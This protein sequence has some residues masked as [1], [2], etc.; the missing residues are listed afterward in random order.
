MMD[1][2]RQRSSTNQILLPP[3]MIVSISMFLDVEEFVNFQKCNQQTHRL[4]KESI[5][6]YIRQRTLNDAVGTLPQLSLLLKLKEKGFLEENRIGFDYA[7]TDIALDSNNDDEHDNSENEE[8]SIERHIQRTKVRNS[9]ERIHL[10][11]HMMAKFPSLVV[12]VEAHAG[13][14]A[15]SGISESFS[16]TRGLA[17]RY[18]LENC[19][20]D[21]YTGNEIDVT[22]RIHMQAWGRR[23]SAVAAQMTH[24]FGD[25]AR[26]GKGWVDIFVE[27]DG[28]QVPPRPSF[29]NGLTPYP[30]RSWFD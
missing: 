7:S 24:P 21:L 10:I 30:S 16:R 4:L 3:E 8:D 5:P 2:K 1:K 14:I 11:S 17:V 26:Q 19:F 27:L 18:A 25:L 12:R 23:I 13:T 22:D 9:I 15:P 28:M 20:D 29:Y 6:V